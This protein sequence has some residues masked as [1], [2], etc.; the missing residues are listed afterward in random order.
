MSQHARDVPQPIKHRKGFRIRLGRHGPCLIKGAPAL[1]PMRL[2]AYAVGR[3]CCNVEGKAG[4]LGRAGW[5]RGYTGAGS[6]CLEAEM[7]S[8]AL[9]RQRER[10][11]EKLLLAT[12]S[13]L[14][15]RTCRERSPMT[16][17]LGRSPLCP[18]RASVLV[19]FLFGGVCN[20][21]QFPWRIHSALLQT[22]GAGIKS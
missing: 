19:P 10:Q 2:G 3:K 17:N 8:V 16:I 5:Q 15:E 6:P 7:S 11:R 21:R 12:V 20:G 4:Q 1:S 9:Q 13:S 14:S 18:N 22:E